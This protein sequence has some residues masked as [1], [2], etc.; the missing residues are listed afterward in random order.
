MGHLPSNARGDPLKL[1][2]SV[3]LRS[4]QPV[5]DPICPRGF[6]QRTMASNNFAPHIRNPNPDIA[7]VGYSSGLHLDPEIGMY[8]GVCYAD[9]RNLDVQRPGRC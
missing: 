3:P 4:L 5:L 6:Y 9:D 8:L 7:V 1:A 2:Q